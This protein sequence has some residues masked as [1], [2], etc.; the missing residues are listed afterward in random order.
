MGKHFWAGLTGIF[1]VLAT[2]SMADAQTAVFGFNDNNGLPNSGTYS[3]G[4]SFTF[5]IS[6]AFAPGGSMAN[7]DGLSYWLE[8]QNPNAPFYFS[9]TNRDATGSQFTFLQ[10]PGLTYPQALAPSDA[11][12]LGGLT[13]DGNGR[14]AGLYFIANVTI[15]IDPSAAPG[16]YQ[17]ETTTTG[18]KVSTAFDNT[19][20]HSVPI[21]AANYT[22]TIV[23]EPSSIALL[24]SGIPIAFG[25]LRRRASRN[26]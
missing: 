18:G 25:F 26:R 12:D 6:L 17:I 11:K 14:G 21:T 19:G 24:A 8:Q 22:I 1:L 7:V 5:S 10:T 4:D 2:V 9:I 13:P 20:T 15:Q 3:P 16:T 23:P